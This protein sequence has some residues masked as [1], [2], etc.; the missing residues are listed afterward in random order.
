M[1][2]LHYDVGTTI[3]MTCRVKRPPLYHVSVTW[4]VDHLIK[5]PRPPN[6]N[7]TDENGLVI[8]NKDVTRG[9]VRVVT[10]KD[11]LS[12][13]LVSELSLSKARMSD[14]GNYTCRLSS[15]PPNGDQRGLYDTISVHVLQGENT[16]AIQSLG[17][18]EYH[19]SCFIIV[20]F[21]VFLL[22]RWL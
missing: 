6:D 4:E 13:H 22:Y 18:K 16:E 7:S 2:D 1:A 12:G 8:L 10:G 20:A 9:G 19:D 17:V 11:K 3:E 14:I 15:V 5:Q 21:E